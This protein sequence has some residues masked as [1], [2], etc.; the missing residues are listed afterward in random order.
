LIQP[1][2]M[3]A[4]SMQSKPPFWGIVAAF[5]AVYLIWGSTY[6]AIRYAVETIP[7]FFM[8]GTRFLAAGLMLYAFARFSGAAAPARRHWRD[9]AIAGGLMLMIGNGGVSW[10]EQ[11]IPSAVAALIVAITPVWMVLFEWLRPGGIRPRIAVLAGLAV[12]FGGVALLASGDASLASAHFWGVA[13]LVAASIGWAAGSIFNRAAQ[14]PGSALLGVAM[15]MIAGGG[16]LLAISLALG[17][18]GGVSLGQISSLSGLA[19]V[20]LVFAGS[21]IGFTA[22]I[23]LL[24]VSTPARVSTYA[25]VN[26]L[27][28]VLLGCTIGREP[29]STNL[30]FGAGLV[31][32]AVV[33]IVRSRPGTPPQPGKE[34]KR[35]I[36]ES[37]GQST[38]EHSRV[39]KSVKE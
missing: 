33:L 30:M 15:Q 22:Y 11:V 6:L 28:A 38:V 39:A 1:I 4:T 21:L 19:W 32:V 2:A 20:Y 12:G 5:A 8:A 16:L 31:I 23:W 36:R 7:P 17:E 24:K 29:F 37:P 26:P 35:E 9:A 25:Y 13:A 27:I 34:T 10:A 3:S 14:K 18:P